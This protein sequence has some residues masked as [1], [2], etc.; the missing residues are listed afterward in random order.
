MKVCRSIFPWES[1]RT[2]SPG[3]TSNESQP[4]LTDQND[5]NDRLMEFFGEMS[6]WYG[7]GKIKQKETIVEGIKNS[8]DAFL[9]LFSGDNIGKMIVK[10]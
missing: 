3:L 10:I 9:G 6:K 4:V 7:S 1:E 2:I 5:Y 8:V